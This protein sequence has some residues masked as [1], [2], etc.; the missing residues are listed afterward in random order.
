MYRRLARTDEGEVHG[1]EEEGDLEGLQDRGEVEQDAEAEAILAAAPGRVGE[2]LAGHEACDVSKR[3]G[4]KTIDGAQRPG[5][6]PEALRNATYRW[7]AVRIL[8]T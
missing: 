3:L 2:R 6:R 4:G 1:R 8:A 7:R 5:F